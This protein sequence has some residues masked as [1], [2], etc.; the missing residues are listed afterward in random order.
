VGQ[1]S[2]VPRLLR[3]R[4]AGQGNHREFARNP[5]ESPGRVLDCEK[6]PD[7]ALGVGKG[8]VWGPHG[9]AGVWLRLL[10][11]TDVAGHRGRASSGVPGPHGVQGRQV[12]TLRHPRCCS[13]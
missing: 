8:A 5:T 10:G 7:P 2:G 13:M 9:P 6:A 11:N 12:L 4:A 1:K 3:A